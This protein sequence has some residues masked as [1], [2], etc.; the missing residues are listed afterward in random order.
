M[1][2]LSVNKP[3]VVYT[4]KL[5]VNQREAECILEAASLLPGF[6]FLLT[7]GKDHVVDHYRR[8]CAERGISNVTF[9]GFLRDYTRV[10]YYQAAADILIS[11]YTD[12][13]HLVR[14]NL[15][16]KIGEYMLTRNPIVTCNYPATADVLNE[17]NALFV[18]PENATALAEGIQ[19]ASDNTEI[20]ARVAAQAFADA[21]EMTFRNRTGILMEFFGTLPS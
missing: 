15:P 8:W 18:E 19:R 16:Q 21:R 9:T 14:Y 5:Y 1:L 12:Q 4:G 11:Y 10:G 7:G 13:D 2:G 20:S 3:L 17:M 6:H